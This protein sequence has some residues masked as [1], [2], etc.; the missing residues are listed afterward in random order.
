ML[1]PIPS[2]GME[3]YPVSKLVNRP[4]NDSSAVLEKL[5]ASI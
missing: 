1:D 5:C 2:K 3:A 4:A